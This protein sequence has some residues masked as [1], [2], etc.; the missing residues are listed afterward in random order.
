MGVVNFNEEFKDKLLKRLAILVALVFLGVVI[1]FTVITIIKIRDGQHVKVF[2]LEYNIPQLHPDTVVKIVTIKPE[3]SI[4]KLEKPISHL[5]APQLTHKKIIEKP[6]QK[7]NHIKTEPMPN[8][9][10]PLQCN[11]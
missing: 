7:D 5:E 6:L 4:P 9:I 10:P 11:S 1:T 3:I 2:G 8:T